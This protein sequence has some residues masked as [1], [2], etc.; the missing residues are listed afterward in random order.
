M[1]FL[2]SFIYRPF[3]ELSRYLTAYPPCK[4]K[5]TGNDYVERDT[6]SGKHGQ[7]HAWEPWRSP[8]SELAE[9]EGIVLDKPLNLQ[10]QSQTSME[11]NLITSVF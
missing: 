9:N 4:L 11:E 6:E 8:M 5:G 1:E 2:Q 10:S 7:G 3:Q